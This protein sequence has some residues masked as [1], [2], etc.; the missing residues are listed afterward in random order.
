MINKVN[1]LNEKSFK[2]YSGPDKE[3]KQKNIIFGYN[4]RGKSSLAK[5]I[6]QEF[7]K[8]NENKE[9]NYRFFNRNYISD[10]LIL[11]ES[12]D[13]KIKGVIANF[14]KKD[15][16]IEKQIE[17]L[18][19]DVVDTKKLEDEI[20][21]LDKN[22]RT[23]IDKIHDNKK[24]NISIQK[25]PTSKTNKEVILLY[26]EDVAKAKKIENNEEK[27]IDF[28]GD[29]ALEKQKLNI[30]KINIPI[31]E[32]IDNNEILKVKDIFSKTYD[33]IE[34][35]CSKVVDWISIG[36]SIHHEGDECK[37][38]G[39]SP[40]LEFIRHNIEK[41]NSNEKQK[42]AVA[43]N[44]FKTKLEILLSQIDNLLLVKDNISNNLEKDV[45]N[46]FNNI[47]TS[48]E[49]LEKI[50]EILV[51]KIE[52]INLEIYFNYE[53]VMSIFKKIEKSY[54]EI[55]LEKKN[56][57]KLIDDKISKLNILIKGAIGLEI[58]RNTF[59]NSNME[60][61][62]EKKKILKE[63]NDKNK[64][65]LNKIEELKMIKSNTKDFAEHISS[66]LSMLEVNLKLDVLNDDYIIKQAITND[67]LKLEDI[68]EGEQN[69]L[70]LLYFYY[71]LFEDNEQK[72]L[73]NTIKLIVI[74]DPIASVDD[75]NK[76]Y[77]LE[78]VKKLCELENTQIFIFTHV[79]DD[80]CNICYNKKD[81]E[82]TPFRFYEVKKDS[83]GSKVINTK[84]NETP[85]KHGFK[86]IYEFSLKPNCN[87][88]SDCEIYH[89]PNIMRK[90]LEEFL[91][92]K[93]KNSLPTYSNFNNIKL[94]LC[95]N[96]PSRND[97]LAIGTLLN[98]CNILSH[99]ASR[100]P[101]EILKAAKFLM[102]K[103]KNVDE[104]HFNTMKE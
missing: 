77:V 98:V 44:D 90:I 27:L 32:I 1:N 5:G 87:D 58:R 54:N 89:Y 3:F 78:L 86:E 55:I 36:L 17:L 40:N 35:P 4:G 30:E 68:S 100:N 81:R 12:K 6:I 29:N 57:I 45:S 42:A 34:I 102:A 38:C 24:G 56:E 73:K 84:T 63:I 72:M 99:K 69:L 15:V 48:R 71:E 104:L 65:N 76:M 28:K 80:F 83:T 74:D 62:E 101:D 13:S 47:Q 31:I 60:L 91:E 46:N 88:M 2:N 64:K 97:E 66:I 51:K 79:W 14:G 67:I 85:Y 59:I 93:V 61:V 33:D 8:D 25:K 52:N 75:V 95:G 16:D 26:N 20:R 94:V 18:E 21:K 37:F 9:S 82:D 39:G 10:N 23:E 70:A 49:A 50:K 43:L 22:I 96:N 53:E 41:Y 92:F 19:L 103:I 11:K 7:L